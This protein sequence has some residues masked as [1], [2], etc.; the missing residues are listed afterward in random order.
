M[1]VSKRW[2]RWL[3]DTDNLFFSTHILSCLDSQLR[4]DLLAL[5]QNF[6]N[7]TVSTEDQVKALSTQGEGDWVWGLGLGEGWWGCQDFEQVYPLG[8]SVGRKMKLVES[9]LEKQ[10][11]DLTEGEDGAGGGEGRGRGGEGEGEGGREGGERGEEEGMRGK[12]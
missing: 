9:K 2:V 8:S 12:G 6:S 10:Q 11:K 1:C 7:L 3:V 4:E 5:R